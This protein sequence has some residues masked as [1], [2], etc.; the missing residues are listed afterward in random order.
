MGRRYDARTSGTAEDFAN[1]TEYWKKAVSSIVSY[2]LA[3]DDGA[4]NIP[5]P[6]LPQPIQG[7]L[8]TLAEQNRGELSAHAV[9]LNALLF[10]ALGFENVAG[11]LEEAQEDV[12]T[13]DIEVLIQR[14]DSLHRALSE[15][16]EGIRTGNPAMAAEL[17]DLILLETERQ[18]DMLHAEESK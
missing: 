4:Q 5:Q 10:K 11:S 9:A 6:D 7:R 13:N 16:L 14:F 8:R 12:N 17:L 3:Y 1:V 2:L 18:Q 15:A